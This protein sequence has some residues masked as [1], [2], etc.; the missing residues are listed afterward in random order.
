MTHQTYL[1]HQIHPQSAVPTKLDKPKPSMVY[2][3]KK[4]IIVVYG[5]EETPP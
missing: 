1:H 3:E 5:I 2:S 4:L